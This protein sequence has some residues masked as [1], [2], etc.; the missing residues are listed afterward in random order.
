MLTAVSHMLSLALTGEMFVYS[1]T[2]MLT[3]V[4]HMLSLATFGRLQNVTESANMCKSGAAFRLAPPIGGPLVQIKIQTTYI[5]YNSY[6]KIHQ[7][8][9]YSVLYASFERS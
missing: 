9:F 6:Y 8:S 4:S 1:F 3:A 7:E 5:I 2:I